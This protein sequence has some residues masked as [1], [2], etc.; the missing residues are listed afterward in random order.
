MALPVQNQDRPWY[1]SYFDAVTTNVNTLANVATTAI[2]AGA[3][4]AQTA[5]V[6]GS[7]A[8]QSAAN[9]APLAATG[10][11]AGGAA[12]FVLTGAAVLLAVYAAKRYAR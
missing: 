12:S 11:A 2:G 3:S 9:A 10:L 5:A 8:F 4:T 6:Q 1:E 7:Q